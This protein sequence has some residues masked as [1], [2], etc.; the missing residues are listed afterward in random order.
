M[1]SR[2]PFPRATV[3]GQPPWEHGEEWVEL[4][5]MDFTTTKEFCTR[6]LTPGEES[7]PRVHLSDPTHWF[8]NFLLLLPVES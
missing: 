4:E 8:L 5:L 2:S 3:R 7:N 1:T 6:F